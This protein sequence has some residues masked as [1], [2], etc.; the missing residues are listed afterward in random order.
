MSIEVIIAT[1]NEPIKECFDGILLNTPPITKIHIIVDK[2]EGQTPI[3][4]NSAKQSKC[5][6]VLLLDD[7]VYL[8]PG[9]VKKYLNKI[10]EGYDGVCGN[11]NPKPSGSFGKYVHK[12]MTNP[13]SPFYAVGC[14]LWRREKFID[15]MDKVGNVTNY[16]GENAINDVIKKGDYKVVRVEDAI[17]DHMTYQTIS[18]FYKKN[19]GYGVANAERLLKDKV[20]IKIYLKMFFGMPTSLFWGGRGVFVYRLATFIGMTKYLVRGKNE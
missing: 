7:D 20:F 14:T 3:R 6:Y 16:I 18:I 19:V 9:L 2:G 15:I 8:R 5:K 12:F 11:T 4:Y 10:E 13:K 17:C 1:R